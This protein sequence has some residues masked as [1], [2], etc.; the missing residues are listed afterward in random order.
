MKILILI[1][2]ILNSYSFADSSF[3]TKEEYAFMMINNPRGIGCNKCHGDKGQGKIISKYKHRNKTI[4]L[5]V[6]D[7]TNLSYKNFQNKLISQKS[8]VMPKYYLTKQEIQIL[9]Y[10]IKTVNKSKLDESK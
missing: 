4:I 6:P 8:K 3:M 5:K 2:L 7:I 1:F 10:Y 9:Y